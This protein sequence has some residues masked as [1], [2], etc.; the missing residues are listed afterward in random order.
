[1]T[2]LL[3]LPWEKDTKKMCSNRKDEKEHS[4]HKMVSNTAKRDGGAI[5]IATQCFSRDTC[6]KEKV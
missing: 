1:M 4:P 6:L 2:Q 5:L 3:V